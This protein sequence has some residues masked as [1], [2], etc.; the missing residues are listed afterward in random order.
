MRIIEEGL[1]GDERIIAEGL[2]QA[3]PG[4]KVKPI[5]REIKQDTEKEPVN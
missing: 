4:G 3:R 1:K 5:E 2:Q